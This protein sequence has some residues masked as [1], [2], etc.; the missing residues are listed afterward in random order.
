[1]KRRT[2]NDWRELIKQ[3]AASGLSVA[4]FCKQQTL[5]QTYFYKRKS[6]LNKPPKAHQKSGFIKVSNPLSNISTSPAI[7]VQYQQSQIS[8]PE[9]VSSL[10]LAEFI[11]ALS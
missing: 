9:S 2:K 5:G 10:W 8:L 6:D 1:M 11:K 4:E 3:Q 7:K